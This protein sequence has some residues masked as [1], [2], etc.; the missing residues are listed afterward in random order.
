MESLGTF[1]GPVVSGVITTIV[2]S[3]IVVLIRRSLTRYDKH[4]DR[5]YSA[6][7][8]MAVELAKC[9]TKIEG[10]GKLID[11]INTH[12]CSWCRKKQRD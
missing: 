8:R 4:I 9:S 1:I 7:N 3:F 2:S 10:M 12:G 5:I 6:Q 11:K